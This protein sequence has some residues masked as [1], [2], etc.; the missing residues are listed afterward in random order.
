MWILEL[1]IDLRTSTDG[2]STVAV[3]DFSL[4]VGYGDTV[5]LEVG[6]TVAVE[7]L[8][9]ILTLRNLGWSGRARFLGRR[10]SGRSVE[11]DRRRSKHLFSFP[12]TPPSRAR[13]GS[14]IHAEALRA[15]LL[16]SDRSNDLEMLGKR[17]GLEAS[18]DKLCGALAPAEV[19]L[20]SGALIDLRSPELTVIDGRVPLYPA[21]RV[22]VEEALLRIRKRSA[23]VIVASATPEDWEFLSASSLEVPTRVIDG[24]FKGAGRVPAD[25]CTIS[26]DQVFAS[27]PAGPASSGSVTIG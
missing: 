25:V 10:V 7:D 26:N 20:L 8:L 6:S 1:S 4:K 15:G 14:M 18:L 5:R 21:S 23:I 3:E 27:G 11:L 17:Y 12:F 16:G 13:C 24:S 22:V 9:E 2:E 19:Q